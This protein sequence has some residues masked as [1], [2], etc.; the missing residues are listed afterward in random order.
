MLS[1]SSHEFKYLH[2]DVKNNK[3]MILDIMRNISTTIF[4]YG[5]Y[6]CL[7]NK[8]KNDDEFTKMLI[9]IREKQYG[10]NS[11]LKYFTKSIL[12]DRVFMLNFFKNNMT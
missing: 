8:L 4:E 7:S 12:N 6:G 10:T 11:T 5:V 2:D 3:D 1:Y 9:N